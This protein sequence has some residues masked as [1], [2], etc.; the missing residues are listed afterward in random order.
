MNGVEKMGNEKENQLKLLAK[1]LV[2][3]T[4]EMKS[5]K[6]RDY[7]VDEL[8]EEHTKIMKEL[9]KLGCGAN[10]VVQYMEEYRN[11]RFGEYNDWM[12]GKI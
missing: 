3:V 7:E 6:T 1:K 11:L 8:K 5:E 9:T 12:E 2:W 10:S 4:D